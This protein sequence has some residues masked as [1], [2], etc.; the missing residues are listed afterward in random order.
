MIHGIPF[1]RELTILNG[2]KQNGSKYKGIKTTQI[3]CSSQHLLIVG[4]VN[5]LTALH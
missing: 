3:Q 1:L 4:G 2:L 5:L